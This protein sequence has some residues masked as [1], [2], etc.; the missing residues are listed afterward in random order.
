MYASINQSITRA[1]NDL[2]PVRYQAMIWISAGVLLFCLGFTVPKVLPKYY[3][4]PRVGLLAIVLGA[5]GLYGY[6][7]PPCPEPNLLHTQWLW[8]MLDWYGWTL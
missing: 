2:S 8:N 4:I 7:E 5:V 6:T 3:G 1:D